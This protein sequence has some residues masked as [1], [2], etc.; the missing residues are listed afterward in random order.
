[1]D[2]A[3][4]EALE[5]AFAM[6]GGPKKMGFVR[7]IDES[8]TAAEIRR[9]LGSDVQNLSPEVKLLD[10][11]RLAVSLA[12]IKQQSTLAKAERRSGIDAP[13]AIEERRAYDAAVIALSNAEAELRAFPA[14]PVLPFEIPELL[15]EALKSCQRLLVISS[16]DLG[17]IV[18]WTFVKRV[19]AA[20]KRNVRALISIIEAAPAKGPAVDLER[21]RHKYR[22]LELS[23][24]KRG[25]FHHLICDEAFA[26]VCNRPLLGNQGKV[27]T[28]SH[29][30]GYL[31]QTPSLV[32]AFTDR[33]VSRPAV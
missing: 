30:S 6:G 23:S 5:H 25:A 1:V 24:N 22:A 9:Y 11:K 2:D 27:R 31:L 17:S 29:V 28:F 20:L 32:S 26:V 19:E 4:N 16:R 13:E 15:D 8:S 12:R 18:D 10:Q 21:L 33:V 14:R 7:S 3:R